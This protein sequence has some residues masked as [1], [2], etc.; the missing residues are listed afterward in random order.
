MVRVP[1]DEPSQNATNTSHA[2]TSLWLRAAAFEGSAISSNDAG[3]TWTGMSFV[4]AALVAAASTPLALPVMIEEPFGSDVT[5]S[6]TRSGAAKRRLPTIATFNYPAVEALLPI[7][8]M[9]FSNISR[10]R[11]AWRS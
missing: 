7:I 2:S 8:V 6:V 10:K 5:Y 4:R 11:V 9:F 3:I 1:F